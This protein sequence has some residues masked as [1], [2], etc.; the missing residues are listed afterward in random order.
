MNNEMIMDKNGT[1]EKKTK[2]ILQVLKKRDLGKGFGICSYDKVF[3]KCR[4]LTEM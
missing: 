2:P 1:N 3:K 4:K